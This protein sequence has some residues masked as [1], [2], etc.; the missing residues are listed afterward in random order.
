MASMMIRYKMA[1]YVLWKLHFDAH[2]PS[3]EGAGITNARV[4]RD[5]EDA[6]DVVIVADVADPEVV[7]A[8][9]SGSDLR[10]AMENAG[11]VAAPLVMFGA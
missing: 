4:Y 8:W 7:K 10:A 11:V 6:N 9:A 5:V 2:R 1:S 3:R